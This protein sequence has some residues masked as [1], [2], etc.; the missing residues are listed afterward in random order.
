MTY[1]KKC[2]MLRKQDAKGEGE[3]VL[4]KTRAVIR[5]LH[6]QIKVSMHTVEAI[7][8]R[9]RILTIEELQPQV[10]NLVHGL[11][12]MW[13]IMSECHQLQKRTLDEAKLLLA[14][15][16]GTCS[17]NYNAVTSSALKLESELRNWRN[18]FE[19]WI[20][21]QRCYAKSL[22]G[23]VL[24][25]LRCDADSFARAPFSPRRSAGV[26]P[27][28][29]ICIQFSK[30][31]DSI[32]EVKVIDG[33]EFFAAGVGS[34]YAQQMRE[35]SRRMSGGSRRFSHSGGGGGMLEVG[36]VVED[37]DDV[38]MNPKKMTELSMKV[39][40][41]GM[42]VAVSSLKEFALVSSEGYAVLIQ[43]SRNIPIPI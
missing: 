29:G 16:S 5:N 8:K 20:V 36:F 23:W 37:E 10:Q 4:D 1:E 7:S 32:P 39:L 40:C 41:A 42:S 21:S 14:A 43:Q 24:R 19:S 3:A 6:T 27:V 9:I 11:S 17:K 2:V 34:V 18:C 13:K 30:L 12:K 25:C 35:E 28:F 26:P 15:G 31:L 38:F 33:L 22:S